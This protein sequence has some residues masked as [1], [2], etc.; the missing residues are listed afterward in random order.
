[1]TD[2]FDRVLLPVASVEDA[3]STCR[4]V[5][6]YVD[7][8]VLA[9]HVVE[10]AG[11][12][13]DKAGVEQRELEAE[14]I[15][16]AVR[17]CLD[18]PVSTEIL[19]GTDVAETIFAAAA[20]HDAT[21]VVIT[22]RGGGR[23][24]RL[25][26]GTLVGMS[27]SI[28]LVAAFNETMWADGKDE[29]SLRGWRDLSPLLAVELAQAGLIYLLEPWMLYPL[30]IYSALS[31]LSLFVL[32]GAMVWVMALGL[33]QTYT[34]WRQIWLPLLWGIAFAALIIGGMD[35]LRLFLTGTIDGMPTFS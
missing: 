5:A 35:A 13:P 24:L 9:V 28:A 6:P 7:G 23:W 10:K 33:D 12:A 31:V 8:D 18:H 17:E 27:M 22:P 29:R 3:R 26:T 14:R 2:L 25:L 1:M 11:G 15:F 30:S 19:Y 4:A 34:R 21:A 20:D 16:D 32:L